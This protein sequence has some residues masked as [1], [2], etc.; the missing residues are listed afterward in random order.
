MAQR[1]SRSAQDNGPHRSGPAIRPS[2]RIG[3]ATQP[4]MVRIVWASHDQ[5]ALEVKLRLRSGPWAMGHGPW[6][7]YV[8]VYVPWYVYVYVCVCD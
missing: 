4:V 8:Y 5:W 2:D 1:R 7:V 3:C 6:Y